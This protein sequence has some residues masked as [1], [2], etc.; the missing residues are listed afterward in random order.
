MSSS[1]AYSPLQKAMEV[2]LLHLKL[3]VPEWDRETSWA[4]LCLDA[5][6]YILVRGEHAR[7]SRGS[8]DGGRLAKEVGDRG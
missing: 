1:Y 5:Q 8:G 7:A 4:F 2:L 6:A 3:P